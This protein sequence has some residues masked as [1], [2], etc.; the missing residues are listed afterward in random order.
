MV[1]EGILPVSWGSALDYYA[2]LLKRFKWIRL[3]KELNQY[4]RNVGG[5][6]LRRFQLSLRLDFHLLRS[7]LHVIQQ[8]NYPMLINPEFAKRTECI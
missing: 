3:F 5:A 2:I 4:S 8:I 1:I 7:N 6:R